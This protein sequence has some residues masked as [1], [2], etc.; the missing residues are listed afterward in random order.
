LTPELME[1]LEAVCDNFELAWMAGG[2]PSLEDHLAAMPEEGRLVLFRELMTVEL[3]YRRRR[4]EQPAPEEYRARFPEWGAAVDDS[5]LDETDSAVSVSCQDGAEMPDTPATIG[6]YRVVRPLG[7]GGFGRVYLARDD[8]LKRYVAV[9]VPK[10]ERV[11]RPEDVEAYLI[12]ARIVAGLDHP[13]I[14]PV[15][16]VGRTDDGLCFV[17][18]RFIE[19]ADLGSKVWCVRPGFCES[20]ELVATVAEALHYAHTRGLV[21]RDIKPGNILIDPAGKPFVADFGVALKDEDFGRGERVVGTPAYMSPEQARGEGHRVDGRSDIFSLGVVFYELLTGRRPFVAGSPEELRELITTVEP[22]PLRQIDDTIPKELERICSRA[23]GKR[24]SDRYSTARDLAED[25]RNYLSHAESLVI[26]PNTSAPPAPPPG[27]T[28][29]MT[30]LTPTTGQADSDRGAVK[31][32]PQGLRSFDEQDAD[33]FL[34]LLPGPRDRDGLPESIRFWKTRIERTESER[35]FRVGLIYGPSGCGKTSL[36]KAGLLPRLAKWILN[37]YVEAAPD[38][39]ENRLLKAL[40]KACPDLPQQSD[41]V[42]SLALV[43]QGRV[44]RPGQK[45]LLVFD[46]FEQWLHAMPGLE[47]RELVAALR[48]CDGEH[49]QAIVM[50]RDDFWLA[51]SRFMDDLEV[52][53]LQGRNTALVDL[54]A[55][56]HARKVLAAFGRAYGALPGR[57][58]ETTTDQEA[59]LD[60]AV[61]D[62][63][64]DG[65]IV[66]V[67]LA[68]FAEMVKGRPWTP[69]TLRAMGGTRGM[70]VTFLDET[71]ASARANP[72][73]RLHRKAAQAVLKALLPETGIEIKGQ[74]RSEAELHEA[75]GYA[76]RPR[77]FSDLLH[78]LDGELRLITP[79][80]PEGFGE[81][82]APAP[83]GGRYYQLTHDYLVHSLRDWLTRKQRETR[84]GRAE[85]R[86]AELAALW[87]ARSETRFLPSAPEWCRIRALTRPKDWTE[88]ERRMMRRA[89]RLHGAGM[90]GV[91]AIATALVVSGLA[92]RRRVTED[93]QKTYAAGLVQQLLSTETPG[94]PAILSDME[95]YRRWVDPELSQRFPQL[96]EG[97][98]QQLHAGLALLQVDEGQGKFLHRRLLGASPTELPVIWNLLR[99]SPQAPVARLWAVLEDPR[100]DPDQR[101]RAACALANPAGE[102]ASHPGSVPRRWDRESRLV[103][104]CLLATVLKNPSHYPPLIATLRPARQPLIAALADT[105]RDP[106]RSQSERLLAT[107]ILADYASDQPRV[108]ADLLM[109]AAPEQ[110]AALFP[111][112]QA[113]AAQA[114]ATLETELTTNPTP[115]PIPT[116]TPTST[117]TA[118]A[119]P[120]TE[121][122][123]QRKARAAVALMRLGR[124]ED[125][126]PLLRHTSN[127]SVRSYIIHWVKP[128]GADPKIL[129]QEL[130][131]LACDSSSP[132]DEGSTRGEMDSILSRPATSTRRALILA[133]GEYPDLPAAERDPL[134]AKLLEAYRDDPD[135]GI[136]GAA[137]WT[138]REWKLDDALSMVALPTLEDRGDRRWYVNGAG[139]TLVVIAGPVAVAMGSP[140]TEPGR[141][142]DEFPHRRRIDRRFAIATKEVNRMQYERFLELH[143]QHPRFETD[144]YSPAARGAQV[145]LSWYD[146]AAYCNW[147]S[148][149]EGL[150]ACYEPNAEGEYA[151]GMKLAADALK[152]SGYRLPTEA[153][154]EY[155]CRAGTVTSRHY[156]EALSLVRNYAWY[157]QNTP[158]TRAHECG[159]LKPNELG[160]F[161]LLGNV[162]EWCLDP[163]LTYRQDGSTEGFEDTMIDPQVAEKAPRVL[164]GGTYTNP[165]AIVRSAVRHRG[166][167]SH[168]S[169][170]LGFRLARTL[171]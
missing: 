138:L 55:R 30:P 91:L 54:F 22:R 4:G 14:V 86:L 6:R 114:V 32:V 100:A 45:V 141:F 159:R 40:R 117:T 12:E 61:S 96:P 74:M 34:E 146:A 26:S 53:L 57:A 24:A 19:G 153:E 69:A 128:L 118:E 120:E 142:E 158:D 7:Q 51:V 167:P 25:L 132:P 79:T 46:Q 139:H 28:Q 27:P 78:I 18:T 72:R 156:G 17:V 90:L 98:S 13:H 111:S 169:P 11:S 73:H 37:V 105:F 70:G 108:L 163:H 94:V 3:D 125:V 95:P 56:P 58:A 66:S 29:D 41:L 9:K 113:H 49:L 135:A 43:R 160:V 170:Y 144:L 42:D 154:W 133:L 77:D 8:V 166:V 164:R 65:R 123:A 143:P 171:P 21:H 71:F 60:E 124:A 76:D 82:R 168:R 87:S 44:L 162:Y 15:Y 103:A 59:F 107:S 35:T 115:T 47:P 134:A 165:A 63:A 151:E 83:P 136:H 92:I 80:D 52:E 68:L 10:S 112:V 140:P 148:A 89:G 85:L 20:A 50:V 145:A 97:S 150:E 147:L 2:R 122:P 84:R 67:R 101:F 36:V 48:Q 155:V 110:F 129:A 16:D 5:F 102:P 99:E 38:D 81:G 127:P 161:D 109:D 131:S 23:L 33:F 119:D 149:Q 1:L 62:L 121:R 88:P 93:Q 130:A 137:E 64:Q 116:P 75:S 152:R 31:V 104:D 39:T 106:R 157:L 126:W